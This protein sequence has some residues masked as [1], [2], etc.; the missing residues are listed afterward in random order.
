MSVSVRGLEAIYYEDG[1]K[2]GTIFQQ[3]EELCSI[4]GE[5]DSIYHSPPDELAIIDG[6]NVTKIQRRGFPDS[7]VWNIGEAKAGGLKDLGAGE[8]RRYLCVESG[9]IAEKVVVQPGETWEASQC[10]TATS[11]GAAAASPSTPA[12]DDAE[13]VEAGGEGLSAERMDEVKGRLMRRRRAP[14]QSSSTGHTRSWS[15][16]RRR[17]FTV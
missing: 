4:V 15:R 12:A 2:G 3:C 1:T 10:F 6:L 13:V 17:L 14:A 11:A 8:W 7:V 5:V 16:K 9:A